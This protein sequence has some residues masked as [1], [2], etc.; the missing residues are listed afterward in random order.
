MKLEKNSQVPL[1]IQII[2]RYL[3]AG[4]IEYWAKEYV[5]ILSGKM[6]WIYSEL[7]DF[8]KENESKNP[9]FY[10]ICAKIWWEEMESIFNMINDIYSR[11]D[12]P[13]YAKQLFEY[14]MTINQSK[15]IDNLTNIKKI[16]DRID[17]IATWNKKSSIMD[18]FSQ[19][20]Q[21]IEIAKERW[22]EPLWYKTWIE[23]IDKYCEWLQPG[24]VMTINAYSN[25]GKSK[26]SYFMTNSFLKQNKKVCYLSL[27]VMAEKV[28]LNLIA[29]YYEKDYT[30]L[31]K[32]KEMINFWDFYDVCDKNLEI[33]DK[34]FDITEIV[35]YVELSKPD[36]VVIDFIQNITCRSWTSE[37]E[38]M[39]HIAVE[40]QKLAIRNK[41]AI[42]DL[43]QVSNEWTNYKIGQMIPSKWSGALVA[44]TDVWLM[45]YKRDDQIKL[46]IAKNKFWQNGIE[47]TLKVDFS[48]G[49]FV[50]LWES[51]F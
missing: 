28:L 38:K 14:Y 30:P 29:N 8:L 43:S 32:G 34:L 26:L 15:S 10:L 42:L 13:K 5:G 12:L 31:A 35:N 41:I 11:Y 44:S 48:K 20:E 17:Y 46:A 19:V 36:I 1:N 9:E 39:T 49:I 37:Y 24:T 23:T 4:F 33:L 16:F 50:D 47:T 27:E 2:Q 51:V 18:V 25:T 40:I 45:L 21:E 3:I 7:F 6:F 22:D